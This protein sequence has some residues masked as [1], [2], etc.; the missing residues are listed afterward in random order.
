[1]EENSKIIVNSGI[2]FTRL[3]ITTL[4]GLVSTRILLNALGISDFGLFS[5]VGGVVSLMGFFNTVMISTTYRFIG[6]EIGKGS[7]DGINKVFNIS[8]IIHTLIA[9]LLILFSETIGVFYIKNYLNVPIGSLNNALIVFRF[10]MWGAFATVLSVPF[11]GLITVKE[12]FLFRAS[13]EIIRSLLKLLIVFFIAHYI[14]N[15]LKVYSF[16]ILVVT[17]FVPLLFFSYCKIKYPRIIKWNFQRDKVKYKEMLSFSGW[18]MI[19]AST[20]M[21]KNQVTALIINSFFGTFVNAALGIASQVR[22]LIS[23]FA[24]NIGQAAIPQI[25]KN[26]SGGNQK[27]SLNLTITISK[28]SFFLMFLPAIP[29]LLEIDL[30]LSLWLKNLPE[31][32]AVFARLMIVFSLIETTR[33]GI[34]SY[35]QATGKLKWFTLLGSAISLLSLPIAWVLFRW[36][37]PPY[38]IQIVFIGSAIFNVIIRLVLLKVVL[39]INVDSILRDIYLKIGIVLLLVLPSFLLNPLFPEGVLRLIFFSS[40]TMLYYLV[41]VYQYGFTNK[42]RSI[43]TNII[44]KV[45]FLRWIN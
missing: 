35:I 23:V 28:I 27:R 21:G 38:Y 3:I 37:Y 20:E 4:V 31:Y 44:H 34:S 7:I 9:V 26:Y 5:V 18:I 17:I 41:V 43:I 24:S 11:L 22:G 15:R 32:T 33:S 2:L 29:I 36:G 40:L 42:E 10:S 13:V 6:I 30:I 16:L 39:K 8:V 19:G 25:T 14:G 45:K 12:N 1:M